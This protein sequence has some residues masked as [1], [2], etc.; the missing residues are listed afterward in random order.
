MKKTLVL[1]ASEKP[2]RYSYKAVKLLTQYNHELIALGLR[3]GKIDDINIETEKKDFHNI[4]TITLYINPERQKDYYRYIIGLKPQ[5]IIFNPGTEN[6]EL[7]K[8]AEENNIEV[9]FNCTLIMLNS[10]DF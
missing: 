1:G 2:Q 9:I 4:H 6:N 8:I 10:N 7:A 3:N 5:R